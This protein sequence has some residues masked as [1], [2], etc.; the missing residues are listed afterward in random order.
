M[1][2]LIGHEGYI[3]CCRFTSDKNIL[4]ASG[5]STTI[6]WDLEKGSQLQKY[7]FFFFSFSLFLFFLFLS[8]F[9]AI[10]NQFLF[11]YLFICKGLLAILV[12]IQKKNNNTINLFKNI[13]SNTNYTIFFDF[14]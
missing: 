1:K 12:N 2:K 8:I 7:F 13:R 4:T 6:L 5:D 9:L 14:Y 3:S 11:I 10:F